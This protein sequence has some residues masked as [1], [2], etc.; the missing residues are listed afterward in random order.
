MASTWGPGPSRA[1]RLGGAPALLKELVAWGELPVN[2]SRSLHDL[3]HWRFP[4]EL[5]SYYPLRVVLQ[6]ID[7]SLDR[8][9]NRLPFPLRA[10]PFF[11]HGFGHSA[12][13]YNRPP[14]LHIEQTTEVFTPNVAPTTSMDHG[15]TRGKSAFCPPLAPLPSGVGCGLE[16]PVALPAAPEPLAPPGAGSAAAGANKAPPPPVC[17]RAIRRGHHRNRRRSRSPASSRLEIPVT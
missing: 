12:P 2:A 5:G 10:T 15:M 9:L 14:G 17:K 6:K 3:A 1:E 11:P 13:P 4:H 8:S 16:T 7:P